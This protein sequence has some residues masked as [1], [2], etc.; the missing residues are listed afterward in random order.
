[1]KCIQNVHRSVFRPGHS[2]ISAASQ[3]QYQHVQWLVSATSLGNF[4]AI[5][6]GVSNLTMFNL[7]IMRLRVGFDI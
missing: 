2:T 5:N 6:L 1:M 3:I 7:W 4:T